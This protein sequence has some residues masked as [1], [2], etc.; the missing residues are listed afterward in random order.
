MPVLP[1]KYM[2][3]VPSEPPPS[4]TRVGEM[5]TFWLGVSSLTCLGPITGL[6]AVIVGARTL[7]R[8][9]GGRPPL[10]IA[11]VLCGAFGTAAGVLLI[12]AGAGVWQGRVRHRVVLPSPFEQV[13]S[14]RIEDSEPQARA[15]GLPPGLPPGHPLGLPPG[16]PP[17]GTAPHDDHGADDEPTATET[18][19]TL[20][21]V[22]VS[23]EDQRSL[24]AIL[25]AARHEPDP[26]VVYVR[27]DRCA[28]CARFEASLRSPAMQTAL[29]KAVL[30]AVDAGA[31]EVD[32]H[33]LRIDTHDVPTFI[34]LAPADLTTLDAMTGVEW[35]DDTPQNMAPVFGRF[36][37]GTLQKRR[38]AP[39]FVGISL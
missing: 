30:V 13:P 3:P 5:W 17:L 36:L 24:P 15:P 4:P 28:P 27:A 25:R 33:T 11:G 6:L 12:V 14:P 29:G 21:L 26:L 7:A 22:R 37:A 9:R 20:T 39:P 35:D 31:F 32:L 8:A 2:D 34:R 10:A 16:H 18:V 23:N 19:G 38:E 1:S